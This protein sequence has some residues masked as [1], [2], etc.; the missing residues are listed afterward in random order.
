MKRV[1][2]YKRDNVMYLHPTSMT[3]AG[4]WIATKP[5]I[6]IDAD[7]DALSIVS[8]IRKLLE[9]SKEYIP[10]PTTGGNVSEP[11]LKLAGVSSYAD[12]M[13]S[14]KSCTVEFEY[15]E[16]QFIPYRN[17]G[18]RSGFEPIVG[19]IKAIPFD[20]PAEEIAALLAIAFE[21]CE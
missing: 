18:A 14:A 4:I 16:L 17:L 5:Y 6:A 10:H 13:E 7:T 2:I 3:T 1:D 21:A 9:Y 11:I 20:A 15:D 8:R 19:Q 12:F